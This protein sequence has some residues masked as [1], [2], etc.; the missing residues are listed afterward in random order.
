MK[1][2]KNVLYGIAALIALMAVIGLVALPRNSQVA[3]SLAINAPA[4][5]I[6]DQVNDLKKNEAWSPWKDPTMQITY[7]AVT[8][9]KGASSSWVSDKMGKGTMTIA[10]SVPASSINI[11][12]DFGGMG[13]AKAIW[14]FA[15]EGDAI[16]VTE[17]M[18]SDAGMNPM[19]RWMSLLSDK[20]VGGY[21]EKGLAAL[22]QVSETR[23]AE[24]K[25]EQAETQQAA[26]EL[27]LKGEEA[28]MHGAAPIPPSSATAPKT[29]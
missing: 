26:A 8:E 21:F 10:E 17:V 5:V 9:G 7:G 16:K 20:M 11:D 6:F 14:T 3:R 28:A 2:L 25:T 13:S 24:L 29:P 19:K 4:S 22:K 18:T 12:L 23:A 27:T 15:P 1:I